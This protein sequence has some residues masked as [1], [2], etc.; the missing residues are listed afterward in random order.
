M[1]EDKKT[2]LELEEQKKI[3]NEV[4]EAFD[5]KSS[6]LRK[7]YSADAQKLLDEI[8]KYNGNVTESMIGKRLETFLKNE[9]NIPSEFFKKELKHLPGWVPD[10]L[11]EDFYT[12]IDS[13]IKWQTSQYYYRRTMRTKRYGA[14]LDRYFRIMNEYHSMGIY[15]CDIASLY[16]E[17]LPQDILCYY[18][19]GN[20]NGYRIVSEYWIQA[21]LDR[22]NAELEEVLMDIMFGE[23]A[24]ARLTTNILRGIYMSSSTRLHEAVGKL[25]I[26]AKLQEGL[27]QAI[28]ENMDYGTAG[29]FMTL[30][31]V[32]KENDLLRFSSVMRAVAT[33]TGLVA[34]EESKLDH[35]QKKQL[36]LI[37]TYLND[38][39]A[40]REALSGED[41][42][43]I[44]LALWSYGFF[45]VD[46]ACHVMNKLALDGSRH[47]R[48]VFGTYIRAMSLGK[49]YTHSVAKEFIKRFPDEMDT[50]AV[51]M[52]SFMSD[53]QP[54]MNSLIYKDGRSYNNELKKMTFAEVDKYFDNRKECQEMYDILM[55]ILER[56]PKKRLE[57]DP[58]VFPWNAEYL[59]R[60]AIIM[61]LAVCASALKDEDKITHIAEMVPEI[62]SARYSRDALLLLLV[63]E[64][65][66]DRQR[67]ILVE[68]V[69]DKETYTRNKAAMIVKDMKFLP[70][71]YVQL[72]N[73]LKYK[74]SDIRETVLSI[75]YKLDGDDMDDLIGRL[76]ADSKEEKRTAGLDLLLQ[77]KNDENRQELFKKC[78]CRLDDISTK[79]S[80]KEEILIKEI[81]D[82][83]ADRA[84]AAEGYGLYDVNVDY[85]P[86]FDKSYLAECLELY[87]K[88]FPESG[89]ANGDLCKTAKSESAFAKLKS[90]ILPK[91]KA[92]ESDS[93]VINILRKLDAFVDEYKNYEYE[94]ADGEIGLLGEMG[95]IV[96]WNRDK[97]ACEELWIEFYEKNIQTPY[98]CMQLHMYLNGYNSDKKDFK[99]YC[100]SFILDMFGNIYREEVPTFGYLAIARSVIGFLYRRYVTDSDKRRLAV[101]AADYLLGRSDELIYTFGGNKGGSSISGDDSKVYHRSVLTN[102]QIMIITR[103]LAIDGDSDIL[104]VKE[105]SDKARQNEED[106]RHL[107]PYNYALAKCHN[108]NIPSDVVNDRD[109]YYWVHTGSVMSVPSLLNYIAAYSR[110]IISRDYMYKMAFEGNVLNRNLKCV[111]DVMRFITERNRKVQ[112]R[113][114]E[115][116]FPEH[117]RLKSVRVILLH[118]PEG[119]FSETDSIRLDIAK[120]LYTDMSEL[121]LAAELTRGDTETEFSQHIYGLTRVY[122]AEYFVR[123]LAALGK[124]TLE[125]STYFNTGYYYNRQKVSK[126]NSMSHLLQACM[127]DA[128]DSAETLKAYLTGTDISDARLIEAA[129]YSPEWIDIVGEYLGWDGFTAGCYYF[130]AHMNESFDDKRKAMIARFTPLEVDELNDGAF[131]RTWFTEVYDRLGDKRFQLI[132][133]AAKYISD[134][135]KHTRARKYADAAL[136]KYDETEL[137]A[138]IEAKR[139]KDLLM[140]VGILPIENEEQIKDR[141]MFLQKF[142]KES[143][144]FGAQ[145]RAS[146]AA[147]VSIAMRNMA[148]NAGYQDVTRLTLR[149]ES[150]MAQDMAE[151]FK[152][153][154]VGE[155]TVWLEMEDGGKCAVICEKNGKQLKSVPAKIKK[156]EYVL[157]L[158]D[159]KKQ[160]AEQSRRTKAMLEDAMESQEEYTWAEIRGMLE[161]PVIHDMV[162]A[163]VFKVAEPDGVKAELDN[164]ADSIMSGANELDDSKN[165][166]LGF[167]AEDGFNT[168]VATSIGDADIA[169]T[170]SKSTENNSTEKT[171]LNLMNLSDDTK[172]T[173]AHPFHMYMV[174]K[175][176]DIQKYVFDNKIVQPFKQ[177]F[178]ELYVKTEEEMNMEHS[179]R[180]A[181]NQIQPKKTL[182]CLRSRHWV[183]DIED[184]LQKVYYKENIVAQIYA[185]ADWFSPAD[186][187]S[188]TLEWVVFSD[189]KTG[190][191]MRIK[192]IPDI[193]FSE[194]MRDVDMAVSVAHAGGVDPETSHSTVEMRKA[195][196]EF[197]MPLFRLTNVTFTKNHA[198]IEGKRANYTV[199]LGSGVVHQEAGPMINVLPVH[200]QR[201]GRIFLPFVDDDPK[202]SEVLTKILFFAEDNKIKDPYILSQIEA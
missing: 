11:L 24:Q 28:C 2:R 99:K 138:E 129:M 21:E 179:L 46:E 135:A 52:P 125:R 77:L 29:A 8:E 192:D 69:A 105:N 93:E 60:S 65:A 30:F 89:I 81:K 33:W 40:R 36:L 159:A 79:V 18:R 167:A 152:P 17:K 118:S 87:K 200:S 115:W 94:M 101:V 84:G 23:S 54:Y 112:T 185:L 154:E 53:Y 6:K 140:A 35:I 57:F 149:M 106:F 202:T 177:V 116:G 5:A 198:V 86:V 175:W 85:E 144:Q 176:H 169:D 4:R 197:T 150:L 26:A 132:Y 50:M 64:P 25:L 61:R 189:R 91:K 141:Y 199:H 145:R 143:K 124:E 103:W 201:R 80:T 7:S 83:G 42:M 187:E 71:N 146:E 113:G 170:V 174:G 151:Y 147:A 166:V 182:G 97:V 82:S 172:L 126:K 109:S 111:S 72:E 148:I 119:E 156:D 163:L 9:K 58:C 139:N 110:G 55:G 49:V 134:G 196:A 164:T 136:G 15:G 41:A 78:V 88:Y 122:G 190:K 127:P 13:I 160:M 14:F 22:G 183:A 100:E 191:N 3:A 194:V 43:Q 162:A 74:K 137:I 102:E 90:K 34:D 10:H 31:R 95:G 76:L 59:D 161:N 19:D 121:V 68:A 195:I 193:I 171:G 186:I 56:M 45:D 32:I 98:M 16:K 38:E 188:P 158:M 178:R 73:M 51:I 37:D 75:L 153:H 142:K 66:N 67:A 63:R 107:F 128:N 96:Y 131:D 47:Q 114:Y 1:A 184:G 157:A 181:G 48:L 27:R 39:N 20:S 92:E 155:V 165:V 180:Y 12:S 130:M 108:F 62:D 123:I 117:D 70:E 120:K 44:Y 133:K 168:F 173:V 104:D